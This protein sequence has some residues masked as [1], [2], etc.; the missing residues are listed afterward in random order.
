MPETPPTD[1]VVEHD[2]A[3]SRFVI[4]TDAGDAELLYGLVGSRIVLQHTEVPPALR[5]HGLAQ[6]LARTALEYARDQGLGVI[7]VCPFVRRFL[8]RHPEYQPLV[9]KGG[10]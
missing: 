5:A 2:V 1:P 6:V 9:E 10:H 4:R 3:G 7:P 8:S